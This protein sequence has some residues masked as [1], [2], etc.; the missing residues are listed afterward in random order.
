MDAG[1]CR[2]GYRNR[3][4][5]APARVGLGGRTVM[6]CEVSRRLPVVSLLR[7]GRRRRGTG[8]VEQHAILEPQQTRRTTSTL[9]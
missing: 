9:P 3:M 7:D 5:G 4:R 1:R 8:R 6:P 2:F